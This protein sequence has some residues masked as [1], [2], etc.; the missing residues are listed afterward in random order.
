MQMMDFVTA[1]GIPCFRIIDSAL[2]TLSGFFLCLQ[3]QSERE[4]QF[5][6]RR[7]ESGHIG[8]NKGVNES[9]NNFQQIDMRSLWYQ[10]DPGVESQNRQRPDQENGVQH[11]VAEQGAESPVGEEHALELAAEHEV[12]DEAAEADEDGHQ[13]HPGQEM[14]QLIALPVPDVRESHGLQRSVRHGGGLRSGMQMR[15]AMFTITAPES[16]VKEKTS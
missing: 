2:A 8:V 6:T 9:K 1:S 12:G 14:A 3:K 11:L 5:G 10:I 13:R 7:G 15:S 4:N 16:K